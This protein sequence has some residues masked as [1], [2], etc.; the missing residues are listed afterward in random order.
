MSMER[1]QIVIGIAVL[2]LSAGF[3]L[4]GIY[5]AQLQGIFFQ[6]GANSLQI[7]ANNI[8]AAKNA[9]YE[10]PS[11][12]SVTIAGN[13]SLCSWSSA[14]DAYT[15]AGGSKIYNVSYASGPTL[16][17]GKNI[18]SGALCVM[19][20]TFPIG[21]IFKGSSAVSTALTGGEDAASIAGDI[22]ESIAS[23]FDTADK[24]SNGELIYEGGQLIPKAGASL[25]AE[26]GVSEDAVSEL[27]HSSTSSP[28]VDNGLPTNLDEVAQSQNG[29]LPL[30]LRLAKRILKSR[31]FQ[32]FG[33]PLLLFWLATPIVNTVS[34]IVKDSSAVSTAAS[35]FL[36]GEPLLPQYSG[37]FFITQHIAQIQATAGLASS[38]PAGLQKS[39]LQTSIA[40]QE[41]VQAD[42]VGE[43]SQSPSPN[44]NQYSTPYSGV[45]APSALSSP[46]SFIGNVKVNGKGDPLLGYIAFATESGLLTYARTAAC[47][48]NLPQ[49]TN[50]KAYSSVGGTVS[51]FASTFGYATSMVNIFD[52]LNVITNIGTYFVGYGGEVYV[53]GQSSSR[54]TVAESPIIADMSDS[55]GI[56]ETSTEP[57]TN[58]QSI[59]YPAGNGSM[60]FSINQ[61]IYN[62]MCQTNDPIFPKTITS[63]FDQII[64]S[65][66]LVSKVSFFVPSEYAIGISNSSS[67]ASLCLF[68]LIINGYGYPVSKY[69]TVAGGGSNKYFTQYG[70]P[71]SCI[72]LT[73]LTNG[74][75]NLNFPTTYTGSSTTALNIPNQ[76]APNGFFINNQSEIGFS[77]PIMDYPNELTTALD[78]NPVLKSAQNFITGPSPLYLFKT[79]MDSPI[80]SLFAG[81]IK[82]Q[83]PKFQISLQSSLLNQL[84]SPIT[85]NYA[86][87]NLSFYP[88]DYANVTFLVTKIPSFSLRLHRIVTS[89]GLTFLSDNLL[90]GIYPNNYNSQG[91]QFVNATITLGDKGYSVG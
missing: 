32:N 56:A 61:G 24:F 34:S 86:T 83:A 4:V 14:I 66:A 42:L 3:L 16:D 49:V 15:C 64:N 44:T 45:E 48:G 19:I 20:G 78:F 57:G 31:I 22:P 25:L 62:T 79:G 84:L 23:F 53:N 2:I 41:G 47:L 51:N 35:V 50:P 67:D 30:G 39:N 85:L 11:T 40:K 55:C 54:P 38:L 89:I 58:L 52:K 76:L 72:N 75:Y 63:V 65:K 43:L 6:N 71:V 70:S 28:S 27:D 8:G 26:E 18:F 7:F 46:D 74:T 60:S 80:A 1:G 36:T 10:A 12:M 29:G 68:R 37:V 77:I 21:K 90:F 87:D 13:T 82:Q 88:T 81:I 9:L 91:G 17:S 5:F 33:V 59:I 69:S 73:A